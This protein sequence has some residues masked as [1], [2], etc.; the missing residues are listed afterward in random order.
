MYDQTRSYNRGLLGA[1][2][3]T[4]SSPS[5]GE[6]QAGKAGEWVFRV[7]GISLLLK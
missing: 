2:D 7:L 4:D 6:A 5:P 1:R 3:S